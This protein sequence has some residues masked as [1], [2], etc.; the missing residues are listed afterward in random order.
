MWRSLDQWSIGMQL[1]RSVNSIGANIA[2][3]CGRSHAPD[4]RRFFVIARG[5]L[6]ETEHWL[7]RA[8]HLGLMPASYTDR[9][10]DIARPL[11][12]LIKRPTPR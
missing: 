6:F 7:A 12:G 4:R 10:D 8:Q 1:L 9:L 2:E 5:S 3:G 11:T